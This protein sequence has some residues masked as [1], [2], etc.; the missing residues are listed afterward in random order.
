MNKIEQNPEFD[1]L[2]VRVVSES[3]TPLVETHPSHP[4][5]KALEEIPP[6][7]AHGGLRVKTLK[8]PD[9]A[10]REALSA[11][12]DPNSENMP[13]KHANTKSDRIRS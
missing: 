8:L 6:S 7:E 1:G 11:L 4:D 12:V 9:Y 13:S 10:P 3:G 5:R 2:R